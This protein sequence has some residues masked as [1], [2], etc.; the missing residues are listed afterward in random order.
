MSDDKVLDLPMNPSPLNES[1][2]PMFKTYLLARILKVM[3]TSRTH[4]CIV[5]N[6]YEPEGLLSDVA[7]ITGLSATDFPFQTATSIEP[8]KASIVKYNSEELLYSKD[9]RMGLSSR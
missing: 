2:I 4:I 5:T 1:T 6:D 8:D 9:E 3:E 7:K